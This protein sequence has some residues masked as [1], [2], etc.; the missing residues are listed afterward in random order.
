MNWLTGKIALYV[1]IGLAS[2][3]ILLT[4]RLL[5]VG[6]KRDKAVAELAVANQNL[7]TVRAANAQWLVTTEALRKANDECVGT[8][9]AAQAN[10]EKV[11]AEAKAKA[12]DAS[13]TLKAW[14]ERYAKAARSPDCKSVAE[15]VLCPAMRDY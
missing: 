12:A 4:G 14:M 11:V 15:S 5:W 7:Q 8:K 2:L 6:A 1:C 13:K 3:C 10:A 9:Q